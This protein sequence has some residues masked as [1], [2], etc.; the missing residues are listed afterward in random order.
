MDA[1]LFKTR[2]SCVS[3]S[4]S[5]SKHCMNYIMRLYSG[6]KTKKSARHWKLEGKHSRVPESIV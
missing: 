2:L 5:Q 1:T 6:A 4:A 3:L